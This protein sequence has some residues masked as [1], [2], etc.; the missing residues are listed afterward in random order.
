VTDWPE[1]TAVDEEFDAMRTLVVVDDRRAIDRHNGI[2]HE[3][4]TW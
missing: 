3:G 2:I 4:L 1:I